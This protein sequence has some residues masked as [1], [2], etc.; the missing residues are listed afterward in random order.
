MTLRYFVHAALI[1]VCTSATNAMAQ[2]PLVFEV[3]NGLT[4]EQ[5]S[6]ART[7]DP[8][9]RNGQT[10]GSTSVI[11]QTGSRNSAFTATIASPGAAT[12]TL[13]AGSA[14]LANAV[15][16]DSPRSVIAQLQVGEGNTSQVGIIGGRDN[17]VATAQI[18]N[19]LG[20]N[21]GLV[22]SKG[23]RVVYGQAGSNYSGGIVVRNAPPGTLITLN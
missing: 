19:N 23:T 18:G 1:L 16:Q 6:V 17:A 3:Q 14:N 12:T 20:I 21:F 10:S 22:N 8:G 9:T 5:I 13:Q 7:Q 15:I 11:A 2:Q 4:L